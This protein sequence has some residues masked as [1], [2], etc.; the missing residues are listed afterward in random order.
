[1]SSSTN[2]RKFYLYKYFS[3]NGDII[4]SNDENISRAEE[5][6]RILTDQT[7]Y[8]PSYQ[9]LNDP[10]EGSSH[11]EH[12]SDQKVSSGILSFTT[13]PKDPLM[14]V[15]YAGNHSGAVIA[16]SVSEVAIK[17]NNFKKVQYISD[18]KE[19][20]IIGD[21]L[22]CKSLHW[23]YENEYRYISN[24]SSKII[25][26]EKLGLTIEGVLVGARSNQTHQKEIED[27]CFAFDLT[28][29]QVHLR[30]NYSLYIE[31]GKKLQRYMHD[32]IVG[33]PS[34]SDLDDNSY[35]YDLSEQDDL[36]IQ[37]IDD[38]EEKIR[39]TDEY[40]ALKKKQHD[41]S[42]KFKIKYSRN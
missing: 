21:N 10:F 26:L 7:I 5:F 6:Y 31:Q 22:I 33:A 18:T 25:P 15:H 9:L 29:G 39:N 2:A 37:Y 30:P 1:M 13:N 24:E 17:N 4:L 38:E 28:F 14:W 8:I 27:I 12:P 16:F 41:L 36:Y 32:K 20:S 42:K 34:L 35:D 40:K 11:H 23:A 3:L 19:I